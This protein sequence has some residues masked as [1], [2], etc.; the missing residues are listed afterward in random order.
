MPGLVSD[1]VDIESPLTVRFR[2]WVRRFT[3][4]P[5]VELKPRAMDG[6]LFLWLVVSTPDSNDPGKVINVTH[7]NSITKEHFSRMGFEEFTTW[8]RS[9][10]RTMEAHEMDEFLRVDGRMIKNPHDEDERRPR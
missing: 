9:C 10:V 5:N 1:L 8:I 2:S 6:E 3:Y 4:K 7:N